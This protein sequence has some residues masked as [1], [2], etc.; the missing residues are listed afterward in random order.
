MAGLRRLAGHLD[1]V[2]HVVELPV[3]LEADDTDPDVGVL[4]EL[5]DL[6]LTD[7][8]VEEQHRDDHER[9]DR[10]EHLDREV[11]ADLSRQVLGALAVADDRD[12]DQDVDAQPDRGGSRHRARARSRTCPTPA[13]SWAEA[14]RCRTR[15]RRP[16]V[17]STR[18]RAGPTPAT[19]ASRR[20][21]LKV[22]RNLSDPSSSQHVSDSRTPMTLSQSL[23]PLPL[24][25]GVSYGRSVTGRTYLD[26]ASGL[27]LHPAAREALLAA[28]DDGWADPGRPLQQRPPGPPAARRGT[29]GRG[30]RDRR[31]TRRDH[32]HPQ[33]HHQP[34]RRTGGR[35]RR[36]GTCRRSRRAQRRGALRP[37]ARRRRPAGHVCAGRPRGPGG[38]RPPGS[39]RC[40]RTPLS[41]A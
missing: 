15:P 19:S 24:R 33:R 4:G 23:S 17:P 16:R 21:V 8:R 9:D 7:G 39:R 10:V 1:L 40:D 14:S 36:A 20:A 6:V 31:T 41:P 29:A 12:R 32:L 38:P 11:V 28:L 30:R 27:P 13:R 22:L 18:W 5:V 37:A 35:C 25:V 3:P 2:V 34:V 26:S